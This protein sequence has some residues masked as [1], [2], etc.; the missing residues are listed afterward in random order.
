M[1]EFFPTIGWAR[2]ALALLFTLM[3]ILY[4]YVRVPGDMPKNIPK[5]PIYISL[6]GL[7]SDM[8]QDA[9]FDRWLRGPLE[10]YGAVIIWFA[11]RWNVLATRPELLVDMFRHEDIYAK[12]GSQVKIPW[13][14]IAACVGDNIINAHGHNWRLFTSIM[15]PGLQRRIA[16]STQLLQKSRLFVD[17]LLKE[18]MRVGKSNGVAVNA[19]IQRWA[20]SCMGQNFMGVDLE[21]CSPYSAFDG[22]WILELTVIDA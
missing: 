17:Q 22:Y 16:D 19:H 18:Q 4:W 20:L 1:I 3:M 11:G 21:V 2:G 12:A 14:V 9:I 13:S 6:I 5:V 10:E 15:K 7:C 8:G